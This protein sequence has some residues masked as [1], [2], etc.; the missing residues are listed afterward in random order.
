M[1]STRTPPATTAIEVACWRPGA[2]RFQRFVEIVGVE[3]REAGVRAERRD[4]VAAAHELVDVGEAGGDRGG[5][6]LADEVAHDA[7]RGR[8]PGVVAAEL[9]DRV[10]A[11]QR[12]GVELLARRIEHH[13]VVVRDRA[14][15][16]AGIG[17]HDRAR[18]VRRAKLAQRRSAPNAYTCAA[19]G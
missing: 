19:Y 3:D 6:M 17:E 16:I 14:D 12:H 8:D 18:V 13:N 11:D 9:D 7:I 2:T 15:P 5:E 1:K 4:H 10:L